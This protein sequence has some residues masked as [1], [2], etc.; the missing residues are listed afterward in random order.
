MNTRKGWHTPCY[1]ELRLVS[2]SND[3][4]SEKEHFRGDMD[5][6]P[7]WVVE[8]VERKIPSAYT[9]SG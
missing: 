1:T 3:N 7:D 9:G 8:G 6:Y 2:D 4:D 5:S